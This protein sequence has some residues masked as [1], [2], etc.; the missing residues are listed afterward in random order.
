MNE[1]FYIHPPAPLFGEA[2]NAN[3][4]YNLPPGIAALHDE[5]RGQARIFLGSVP[6]QRRLAAFWRIWFPFR[7]EGRREGGA[8]TVAPPEVR[9]E[10]T[11]PMR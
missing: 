11:M 6:P 8:K 1:S 5:P 4:P 2:D 7:R 10:T 9:G 3:N